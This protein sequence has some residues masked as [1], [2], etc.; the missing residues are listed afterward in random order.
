MP[1]HLESMTRIGFLLSTILLFL[2]TIPASAQKE[3]K[4]YQG[5]DGGMMIHVGYL[6]GNISPLSYQAKGVTFGLG[7]VARAHLGQH[8]MVG[9]EGYMSTLKQMK[10]GSFIKYGWGGFLGEFYWSFRHV[11]PY[12]GLTLGGGTQSELLLFDG[13]ATDW[14]PERG[15]VFHKQPFMAIDPFIGC[16]F[17]ISKSFHLTLKADC[18]NSISQGKLM[19]PMGPRFYFGCIFFH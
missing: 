11:M 5:F 10:N 6:Q 14:Q 8:W 9:G 3:H 1:S 18:L 16:D 2:I 12:I 4:V 17:I 13:D 19:M 15:A 7:G